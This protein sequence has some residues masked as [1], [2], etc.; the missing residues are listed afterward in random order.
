MKTVNE[1]N[2]EFYNGKKIFLRVDFNVPIDNGKIIEDY[3]IKMA[4]RTIKYLIER[5][6]KLIIASH[7]GRPEGKVDKSLSMKP[8]A[9][10][11]AEIL[12]NKIKFVNEVVGKK[13]AKEVKNMKNGEIIL[14]ENLRFES[15]ELENNATF[16]RQLSSIADIYINDAF[17]TC[18]RKHASVHNMVKNFSHKI[19]GVLVAKEMK[20]LEEIRDF[21]KRP[22]LIIIGG[23]KISDKIYTLEQLT[24][25]ADKILLGGALAYTFLSAIGKEIGD[26]LIDK[27]GEKWVKKFIKKNINKIVLPDDHIISKNQFDNNNIKNI[28]NKIPKGFKGFDIGPNTLKKYQKI[29]QECNGTIFWNGPLGMFEQEQY[30]KGTIEIAKTLSKMKDK[31]TTTVIGGGDTIRAIN[32]ASIDHNLITHISTGGGA[33]MDFLSGKQLPGLTILD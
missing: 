2:K 23:S 30:S 18:H 29:I 1:F 3:R 24:R 22:L 11:L 32:Y 5:G 19:C 8:V 10:R 27:D 33:A 4:I 16:A 25:N 14:I 26:S 21:P 13:V 7:L 17:G 20:Y 6:G 15:G 9:I 28:E 12:G 31:G